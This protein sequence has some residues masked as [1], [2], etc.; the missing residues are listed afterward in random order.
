MLTVQISD[1]SECE[2]F[3]LIIIKGTQADFLVLLFV[4]ALDIDD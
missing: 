2:L 4:L 3:D 1:L